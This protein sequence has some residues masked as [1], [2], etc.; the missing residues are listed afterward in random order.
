MNWQNSPCNRTLIC[1][2]FE[3]NLAKSIPELKL[4]KYT[5]EVGIGFLP[6]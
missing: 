2:I 4:L 1:Y 6:D 5:K 3:K